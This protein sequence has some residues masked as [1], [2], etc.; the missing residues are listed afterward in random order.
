MADFIIWAVPL[1]QSTCCC[2]RRWWRCF[3]SQLETPPDQASSPPPHPRIPLSTASNASTATAM[4]ARLQLAVVRSGRVWPCR[5]FHSVRWFCEHTVTKTS[6]NGVVHARVPVLVSP[7]V[8]TAV[9]WGQESHRAAE[10]RSASLSGLRAFGTIAIV[11]GA[12][13]GAYALFTT[14]SHQADLGA[15]RV[16][17]RNP[18]ELADCARLGLMPPFIAQHT[19]VVH[20]KG[21]L[22]SDEVDQVIAL[23]DSL[24]HAHVVGTIERSPSG[25]LAPNG[26]WRTSYLHTDGHAFRAMP[27]LMTKLRKAME[28]ADAAEGWGLVSARPS[29]R[30]NFRTVECHE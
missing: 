7:Q 18:T 11:V 3:R 12:A 28:S 25:K 1:T 15:A 21:F 13:A 4:T 24:R 27:E 19:R 16:P 23:A 20:I 5:H 2:H 14:T 8:R 6:L 29:N 17:L 30:V 10:A 9:R 22:T 26:V